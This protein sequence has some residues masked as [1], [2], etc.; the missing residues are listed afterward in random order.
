MKV[1]IFSG[2]ILL[3][4]IITLT[5]YTLFKKNKY[6]AMWRLIFVF[7]IFWIIS[8]YL[9]YKCRSANYICHLDRFMIM[10]VIPV[11]LLTGITWIIEAY[12]KN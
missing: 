4:I 6:A 12:K 1:L 9:F 5:I 2:L 8:W 11:V 10:G 7:D 3:F